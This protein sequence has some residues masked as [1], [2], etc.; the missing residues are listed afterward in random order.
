[1]SSGGLSVCLDVIEGVFKAAFKLP[2]FT[3]D[4]SEFCF[5]VFGPAF[6]STSDEVDSLGMEGLGS[7]GS[8]KSSKEKIERSSPFH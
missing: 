7:S 3:V 4:S 6:W 8:G 5:L 2:G 1:M